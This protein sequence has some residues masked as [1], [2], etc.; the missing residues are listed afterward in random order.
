MTVHVWRPARRTRT[1]SAEGCELREQLR[2][3]AIL[4]NGRE[5]LEL[6]TRHWREYADQLEASGIRIEM[7]D[8]PRWC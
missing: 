2:T 6:C 4:T 5:P 8:S 7:T 1:C 3:D